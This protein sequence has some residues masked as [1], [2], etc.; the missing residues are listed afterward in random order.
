MQIPEVPGGSLGDVILVNGKILH[1]DHLNERVSGNEVNFYEVLKI[2]NGTPLFLEDH[3][4]RLLISL[5]NSGAGTLISTQ[6]IKEAVLSLISHNDNITEGNIKVV[7]QFPGQLNE[8]PRIYCYYIPHYYPSEAER[9]TGVP[10]VLIHAERTNV[11]SKII[12][13]DFRNYIAERIRQESAYEALLVNKEGFITEGSKSNFF[14]IRKNKVITPPENDV[15]PGITRKYIL[16]ICH[17]SG[18]Q[19]EEARIHHA[20]TETFDSCFISGTSPGVL[21]VSHI[22]QIYYPSGNPLLMELSRQYELLVENYIK[23]YNPAYLK[24]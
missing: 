15:L 16:D 12:D 13:T 18:I 9:K 10:M 22:G 7:L 4:K 6:K 23:T 21:A 19:T 20:E 11:H 2:K 14:I 3:L 24:E 5:R 8:E 1:R 17:C